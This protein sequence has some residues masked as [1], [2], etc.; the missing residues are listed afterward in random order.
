MLKGCFYEHIYAKYL[1]LMCFIG[2]DAFIKFN[3]FY[4][5]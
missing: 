1:N 5:L 2:D 4:E 3:A